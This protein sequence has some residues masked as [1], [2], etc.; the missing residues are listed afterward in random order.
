MVVLIFFET[1]IP[2]IHNIMYILKL[3][4]SDLLFFTGRVE[5][6]GK[7]NLRKIIFL[8]KLRHFTWG[9]LMDSVGL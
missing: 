1:S 6:V 2:I 8:F 9:N 4:Y 3:Y 7:G 5:H